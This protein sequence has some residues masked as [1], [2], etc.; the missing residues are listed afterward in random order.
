MRKRPLGEPSGGCQYNIPFLHQS[1][2]R[3]DSNMNKHT[4]LLMLS[5]VPCPRRRATG[6]CRPL[7]SPPPPVLPLHETNRNS[8]QASSDLKPT[9][10]KIA[11]GRLCGHHCYLAAVAAG[12][13][14]RTPS[15]S[16]TGR[17]SGSFLRT[18]S[19]TTQARLLITLHQV[20][21]LTYCRPVESVSFR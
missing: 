17:P 6:L 12:T 16:P 19:R 18:H 13:A 10:T 14:S 1:L 21:T 8:T 3:A 20:S 4:S 2:I 7:S 11:E 15:S 5:R 9:R